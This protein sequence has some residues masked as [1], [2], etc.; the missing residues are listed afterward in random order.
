M[1]TLIY[2]YSAASESAKAL[3]AALNIKRAKREGDKLNVNTIIN[4]G[5]TRI[6][7]LIGEHTAIINKPAAVALAANKLSTFQI[8]S[9]ADV[10]TVP[11]TTDKDVAQDW[12]RAGLF[13][14]ARTVLNGH[15]GEGIVMHRAVG[16]PL[17]DA[18]LYTLFIKK[19]QEYRVHAGQNGAFFWQR[20]AR[21]KDVPDDKVNWEIRNHD[22]GFIFANQN[23]ELPPDAA[24]LAVKAV[25]ALGLDFG[26][27]DIAWDGERSYILE[28]NTA[29]GLTG[30]TIE[31]YVEF[32][33]GKG[34]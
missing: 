17:E 27:C 30:T 23:V 33:K 4:W 2:P 21:R 25:T 29:C 13:V 15:S 19:K 11:F 5:C 22:N 16:V 9:A 26:A 7:R 10:C 20:K 31:K 14:V 1:S 3:A 18:P 34:V 28:V 12:L 24:E 32:F 8:L 6:R